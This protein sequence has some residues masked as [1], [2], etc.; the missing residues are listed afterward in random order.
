MNSPRKR[1]VIDTNVL[2]SDPLA[3]YKFHEHEVV[4]PITVIEELDHLKGRQDQG[5]QCAR[6]A[7]RELETLRTSNP[8]HFKDGIDLP[9]GGRLR[10]ELNHTP[11]DSLPA[12][13]HSETAD[14]RILATAY[15]L[16]QNGQGAVILVSKDA[17]LRIKAGAIG[18]EA[19]EYRRERVEIDELYSG[20]IKIEVAAEIIDDYYTNKSL[21]LSGEVFDRLPL[22]PNELVILTA[23]KQS[24]V[25]RAHHEQNRL[26]LK[27]FSNHTFNYSVVP[28]NIE[29]EFALELLMDKRVDLVTLAGPAGT[30]KT[31]L[32]LM[33][34]MELVVQQD[35]FSRL[36]V[37]RPVIPMGK[38]I[39][40]LPGSLDEKMSVWLKPFK[41]NLEHL[42]DFDGRNPDGIDYLFEDGII[43]VG[44]LS[45]I[46]G[47]SIPNQFIL[48]DECQNLERSAIKSVLTRV[49]ANSR[50][51]LTGDLSQ[52]D[53][54]LLDTVTNGLTH[55]IESLKNEPSVGHITLTRGVRSELATLIAE[56]L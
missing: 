47:R 3:M 39:G 26:V 4:L 12:V 11:I 17:N 6:Q 20:Q 7:I 31:L 35:L 53:H 54:P 27:P 8:N 10:I 49:G 56:R 44:V 43:E 36:L 24:A 28:K 30:G 19:E 21:E 23:G 52:I 14:N 37:S 2:V 25:G 16:S 48:I 45:Y 40:F 51:C 5:G 50:A 33:A 15:H 29:Q 46:R 42:L 9:D 13:I 32:A 38:D 1:Y 34:G 41:D 22:Y 18:I 55:V